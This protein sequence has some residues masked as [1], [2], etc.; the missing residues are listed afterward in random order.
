MVSISF[1]GV[2]DIWKHFNLV[3]TGQKVLEK[4]EYLSLDLLKYTVSAFVQFAHSIFLDDC[5]GHNL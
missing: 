4:A 1:G 2:F 3:P 5:I